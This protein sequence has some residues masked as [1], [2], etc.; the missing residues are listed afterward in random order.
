MFCKDV[1][2]HIYGELYDVHYDFEMR[3]SPEINLKIIL[4]SLDKNHKIHVEK[5]KNMIKELIQGNKKINK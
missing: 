5:R 1:I 3:D 2:F 4:K